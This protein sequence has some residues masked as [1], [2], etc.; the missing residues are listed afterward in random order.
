MHQI[1]RKQQPYTEAPSSKAVHGNVAAQI[2][3][4]LNFKQHSGSNYQH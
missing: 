1:Y 4:K 2:E 3:N